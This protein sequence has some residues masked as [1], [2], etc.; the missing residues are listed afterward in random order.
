MSDRKDFYERDREDAHY[1]GRRVRHEAGF[2]E[3][4]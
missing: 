3:R 2:F 1:E 4:N